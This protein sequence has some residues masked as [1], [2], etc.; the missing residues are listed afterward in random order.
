MLTSES[1]DVTLLIF[2]TRHFNLLHRSSAAC[3]SS[4]ARFCYQHTIAAGYSPCAG[5][6]GR[7]WFRHRSPR[8]AKWRLTWLLAGEA[9]QASERFWALQWAR[10]SSW[11]LSSAAPQLLRLTRWRCGCQRVTS[12][13][14][15]CLATWRPALLRSQRSSPPSQ[16]A[17]YSAE[18]QNEIQ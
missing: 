6:K 3:Q 15:C 11:M 12:C 17:A 2:R 1:H 14:A 8:S 9:F 10:C 5:M 13:C 16:P 4:S 18:D 7:C